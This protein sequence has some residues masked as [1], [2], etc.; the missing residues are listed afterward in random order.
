MAVMAEAYQIPF[1]R[2]M[3]LIAYLQS[4]LRMLL[5][6]IHM[7]HSRSRCVFVMFLTPLAFIMVHLQYLLPDLL[8]TVPGVELMN[9]IRHAPASVFY[10]LLCHISSSRSSHH[11]E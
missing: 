8:P 2:S 7:V 4:H 11:I 5:D 1:S 6:I 10:F 3:P 9:I